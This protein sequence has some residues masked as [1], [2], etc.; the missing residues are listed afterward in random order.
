MKFYLKILFLF[1]CSNLALNANAQTTSEYD[2]I[3]KDFTEATPNESDYRVKSKEDTSGGIKI[4]LSGVGVADSI[5]FAKLYYI[6]PGEF[7]KR[8]GFRFGTA[9]PCLYKTGVS[10]DRENSNNSV[11]QKFD[12]LSYNFYQDFTPQNSFANLDKNWGK[13]LFY[14]INK[15]FFENKAEAQITKNCDE[16]YNE[17]ILGTNKNIDF[18]EVEACQYHCKNPIAITPK[19]DEI[20][21]ISNCSNRFSREGKISSW[22]NFLSQELNNGF[23]TNSPLYNLY[24]KTNELGIKKEFFGNCLNV[25]KSSK[26][27]SDECCKYSNIMQNADAKLGKEFTDFCSIKK[28][29]NIC[30]SELSNKKTHP[31]CCDVAK[32]Y[33]GVKNIPFIKGDLEKEVTIG[34]NIEALCKNYSKSKYDYFNNCLAIYKKTNGAEITEDCCKAY[35]TGVLSPELDGINFQKIINIC[36]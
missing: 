13:A 35:H 28:S 24:Q 6:Y 5:A 18:S 29:N 7:E 9:D 17:F 14:S 21:G 32:Y 26:T 11:C 27:A 36:N 4:S 16:I 15:E 10:V 23:A 8:M 34:R 20:C 1:L 3:I 31:A 2:V 33:N 22:C 12:E 25:W 30:I 19:I